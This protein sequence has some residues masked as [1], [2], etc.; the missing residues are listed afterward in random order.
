MSAAAAAV[1][2]LVVLFLL[3]VVLPPLCLRLCLRFPLPLLQA[4]GFLLAVEAP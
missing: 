4:V 3:A 1:S 2:C